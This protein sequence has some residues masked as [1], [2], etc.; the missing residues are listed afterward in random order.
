MRTGDLQNAPIGVFDSGLGGLTV[1]AALAAA[2]PSE[3]L[4]YLGDTARV[5]YGSR[6]P[7]TILRYFYN[8]SAFLKNLGVKLIVI[9]CNTVSAQV[10]DLNRF[11]DLPVLGVIQPGARAALAASHGGTLAVIGTKAT[12]KS[13]AYVKAIAALDPGRRVLQAACPLFVPLVEEGWLDHPVTRSVACEYLRFLEGT[14]VDTVI[15]GCTHYPL[16]KP[17]LTEVCQTIRPGVQMLDPAHAVAMEVKLLLESL[18]LQRSGQGTRRFFVTD[19]PE[20]AQAV[21]SRFWG[22]AVGEEL[23]FEQVDLEVK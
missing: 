11:L 8:N 19:A 4:V 1:A 3:D 22:Q 7:E 9:A 20:Q 13:G 12:V 15:L 10:L 21:A 2:L 16:L 6:S 23:R 17:L 5:P 14:D 18:H